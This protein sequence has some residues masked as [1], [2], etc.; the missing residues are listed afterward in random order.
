[1]NLPF[2]HPALGGRGCFARHDIP[3]GTILDRNYETVH[4]NYTS[5]TINSTADGESVVHYPLYPTVS[6]TLHVPVIHYSCLNISNYN[7]RSQRK[8]SHAGELWERSVVL[9]DGDVSNS[10]YSTLL[11][12][13]HCV[14]RSPGFRE[15]IRVSGAQVNLLE[16]VAARGRDRFQ[17]VDGGEQR[18]RRT[19]SCLLFGG[20]LQLQRGVHQVNNQERADYKQPTE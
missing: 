4:L 2:N 9:K 7:Y 10:R 1:M 5:G 16:F 17:K 11:C 18:A 13:T 14:T 12:D 8:V 20:G 19:Q 3:R 6:S 15:R